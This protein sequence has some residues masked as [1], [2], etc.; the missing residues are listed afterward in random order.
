MG[1]LENTAMYLHSYSPKKIK[2]LNDNL[3]AVNTTY[4]LHFHSLL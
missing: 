2:C 1:T 3:V 4:Y